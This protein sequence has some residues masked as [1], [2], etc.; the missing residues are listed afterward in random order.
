[1]EIFAEEGA[2]Q[3][4]QYKNMQLKTIDFTSGYP[5][6]KR[7]IMVIREGAEGERILLEPDQRIVD[8]VRQIYPS[9]VFI[10]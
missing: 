8:A 5:D 10:K 7:F 9:K 6:R 2:W 1:M 4:D 3:L